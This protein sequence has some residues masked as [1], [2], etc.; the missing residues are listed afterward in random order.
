M[1]TR[2]K[3]LDITSRKS[4]QEM[5]NYLERYKKSLPDRCKKF[6]EELAQVGIRVAALSTLG[7]GLGNYVVFAKEVKS[8][9]NSECT[10]IMYGRDIRTVFGDGVDAAEISPI[11]MLEYGSGAK[12]EPFKIV[13]D[14]AVGRGTFPGQTH[15]FAW[16]TDYQGNPFEGWWYKS[17]KDG[18]WHLS[19]GVTPTYPMQKAFDTM[20]KQVDKI[21][22]KVF[23]L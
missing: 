3:N 14:L 8:F 17:K 1:A 10:T 6:G 23:K 2:K 22:R 9:S 18:K 20:Q 12:G 11:L 16:T 21:A 5:I 19:A 13:D 4:I 15:A 7:N